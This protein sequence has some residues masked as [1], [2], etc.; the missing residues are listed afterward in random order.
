VWQH[1]KERFDTADG[2]RVSLDEFFD[3]LTEPPYGVRQGLIPIFLFAYFKANE[4]DVAVYENGTILKEVDY[5][6]IERLLKSPEKF[7]MQHVAI[8]GV[9]EDVL[10]HLAPLVGLPENERKL[11]PVVLRLLRRVHGLP[12]FVSRT[13]RMSEEA[14]A[15]RERLDRSNDPVMLLF[16]ELP[17]CL[18][19]GIDSF[20]GKD[21]ISDEKIRVFVRELRD[22]VR[23]ITNAYDDLIREIQ[24]RMATAFE[25]RADEVEEQRQEIAERAQILDPYVTDEDDLKAFVIRATN[26]MMETKAWYESIA[27]LL[28]GK[29]P[30]KWTDDDVDVFR[31]EVVEMARKFRNQ[32]TLIFED[33]Q[34]VE[35]EDERQEMRLHRI[36]LGITMLG[37]PE[38]ETVVQIHPEDEE[39]IES[40]ADRVYET[41]ESDET[42]KDK[43]TQVKLAALGRLIQRLED[44]REA[45]MDAELDTK[46]GHE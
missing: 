23:E 5:G 21:E 17:Q 9:R 3:L 39:M 15:V 32:E 40:I 26:E 10:R 46:S 14:L 29:P 25:V 6:T 36:R 12:P 4:D 43:D 2:R 38:Q 20:L 18:N 8:E 37:E 31:T 41:L 13:S 1:I 11:L 24:R 28:A 42:A 45:S 30:L 35:D 7:E 22:K 44:E 19:I 34:E 33:D 27:A 16:D